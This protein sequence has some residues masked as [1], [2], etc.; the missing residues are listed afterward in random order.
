[1]ITH[2]EAQ[3][4]L[5]RAFVTIGLVHSPNVLRFAGAIAFLE[6]RYGQGWNGAGKGSHN[7]GAI[8]AGARWDGARFSYVDTH[9]NSDGSS[10]PYRVDF[11]A[12]ASDVEGAS[13]L[14]RVMYVSRPT[15]LEE[16]A[17]GSSIGVSTQLYRT[18]YYEGFGST[19][20]KRIA[21][22]HRALS[23]AYRAI[24]AAEDADEVRPAIRRHSGYWLE[25]ERDYVREWQRHLGITADGL[26]GP[27]TEEATRKAQAAAGLIVDGIVGPKTWALLGVRG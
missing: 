16:A 23:S 25:A 15:V 27:I 6:S 19:P 8:Q 10:T 18:R 22:H 14:L 12:Y 20:E 13:D 1:M 4:I 7:W 11:R 17:A 24:A 3:G 21:N 5:R 2:L 9:P 26:F